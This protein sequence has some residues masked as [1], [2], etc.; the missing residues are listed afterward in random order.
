MAIDLSFRPGS[1]SP[2]SAP[3]CQS[4]H[5][6]SI[7]RNSR[8]VFCHT[9]LSFVSFI[10]HLLFIYYSSFI[11][12]LFFIYSSFIP[13]LSPYSTVTLL[14]IHSLPHSP[15]YSLLSTLHLLKHI[16]FFYRPPPHSFPNYHWKPRPINHSQSI[17]QSL[18]QSIIHAFMAT[19]LPQQIAS[20]PLPDFMPSSPPDQASFNNLPQQ[21]HSARNGNGDSIHHRQSADFRANGAAPYTNGNG[22]MPVPNGMSHQIPNGGSRH[23]G[24]MSL[25]AFD[26]PR[27]PPNTKSKALQQ[28]NTWQLGR[29]TDCHHADTSHV[30]C[31]FFRSG[32]CQAGKACPFSHSTD[33]STADTPCKYFAKVREATLKALKIM[34]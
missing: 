12:H 32:Q 26:G 10:I 34:Y 29:R 22:A 33:V 13:P 27:S 2:H 19:F 8:V 5:S 28:Q 1:F 15:S 23:R 20:R 24:T 30:P 7:L 11:L 3:F 21:T 9:S 14:T 6:P 17:T 18:N 31:K 25:G 4:L 16:S